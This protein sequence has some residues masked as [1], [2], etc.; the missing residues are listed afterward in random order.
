MWGKRPT[1]QGQ[2][3]AYTWLHLIDTQSHSTFKSTVWKPVAP[4]CHAAHEHA[5]F[6]QCK[7]SI[8]VRCQCTKLWRR[9][10]Q[11]PAYLGSLLA[12]SKRIS[13][14]SGLLPSENSISL[15]SSS[16]SSLFPYI[17]PHQHLTISLLP[18]H[19]DSLFLNSHPPQYTSILILS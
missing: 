4:G 13:H 11:N 16:P 19:P 18:K 15:T 12:H 9:F 1:F 6:D 5:L 17:Q 8:R 7:V 2:K 3:L 14:D 10:T